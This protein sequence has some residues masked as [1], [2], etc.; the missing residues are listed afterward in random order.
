MKHKMKMKKIVKERVDYNKSVF[1]FL[2]K[3][4]RGCQ[5]SH[6]LF[7]IESPSAAACVTQ[8]TINSARA[9]FTHIT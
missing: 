4:E 6:I 2:S 9:F 7:E 1:V 5:T 8:E 3:K